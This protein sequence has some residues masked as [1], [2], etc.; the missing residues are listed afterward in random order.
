MLTPVRTRRQNLI[1]ER[2]GVALAVVFA[3]GEVDAVVSGELP[4]TRVA[5][6][7]LGGEAGAAE[8]RSVEGAVEKGCGVLGVKV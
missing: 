4:G 7:A 2:Q 1:L 5:G 3:K 6:G 8:G